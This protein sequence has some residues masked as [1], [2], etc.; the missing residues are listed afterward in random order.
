MILTVLV[1]LAFTLVA[2]AGLPNWI[3]YRKERINARAK[4]MGQ[5]RI[6]D[7]I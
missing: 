2:I 3:R 1:V 6:F 5:E 4:A 7:D